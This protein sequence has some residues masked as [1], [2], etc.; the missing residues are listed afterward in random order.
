MVKPKTE[1]LLFVE[2]QKFFDFFD[3][4]RKFENKKIQ[5]LILFLILLAKFEN[6]KIRFISR[7]CDFKDVCK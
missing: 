6:L 1:G 3:F 7:K 4:F 5:L 2:R